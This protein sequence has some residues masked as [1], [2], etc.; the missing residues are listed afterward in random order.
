M[1][2]TAPRRI[3][4]MLRVLAVLSVGLVVAAGTAP[5]PRPGRLRRRSGR[6]R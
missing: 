4:R 5:R 1:V 2:R 3:R 6:S